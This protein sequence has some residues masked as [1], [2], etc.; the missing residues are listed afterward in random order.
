MSLSSKATGCPGSLGTNL[1]GGHTIKGMVLAEAHMRESHSP[2]SRTL[3]LLLKPPVRHNFPGIWVVLTCFQNQLPWSDFMAGT[4]EGT[5][6]NWCRKDS[7]ARAMLFHR[8]YNPEV[9]CTHTS[10]SP[11]DIPLPFEWQAPPLP[12]LDL[13]LWRGKSFAGCFQAKF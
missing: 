5:L 1:S 2:N 11:R 8:R 7:R 4:A 10:Q 9:F 12:R 13:A 6:W 3:E